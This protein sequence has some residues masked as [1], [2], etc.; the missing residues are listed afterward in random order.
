MVANAEEWTPAKHV[1][2]ATMKLFMSESSQR[3]F[4]P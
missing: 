2:A 4:E 3:L 1:A